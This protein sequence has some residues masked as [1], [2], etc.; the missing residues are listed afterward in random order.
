MWNVHIENISAC[1]KKKMRD[2]RRTKKFEFREGV[3]Y[4]C[5]LF[6]TS[7]TLCIAL[8]RWMVENSAAVCA[9]WS[10]PDG[11][12]VVRFA[13]SL[14]TVQKCEHTLHWWILDRRFFVLLFKSPAKTWHWVITILEKLLYLNDSLSGKT[15]PQ[16]KCPPSLCCILISVDICKLCVWGFC[17]RC[18]DT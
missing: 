13:L 7:I 11:R 15:R 8:L 17:I 1:G 18:G 3:V 6:S 14:K 2:R 9:S 16:C 4:W 12:C 10:W 5:I